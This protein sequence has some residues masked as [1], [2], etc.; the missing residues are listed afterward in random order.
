MLFHLAG[1]P[2]TLPIFAMLLGVFTGALAL[3]K[4][5]ASLVWRIGGRAAWRD[6]K[7]SEDQRLT[8]G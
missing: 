4:T 6:Q 3:L 8:S 2:V 5:V 1:H 7:M